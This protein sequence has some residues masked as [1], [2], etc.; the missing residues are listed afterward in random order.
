M[1]T[2]FDSFFES[3][4]GGHGET[5]HGARGGG[6][7]V[8]LFVCGRWND[9]GG[10]DKIFEFDIT[11]N[12][13]ATTYKV[14]RGANTV[15]VT[16]NAF[17]VVL[18]LDDMINALNADANFNDLDWDTDYVATV[19]GTKAADFDDSDFSTSVSGGTGTMTGFTVT[20]SFIAAFEVNQIHYWSNTD[21]DYKQINTTNPGLHRSTNLTQYPTCAAFINGELYAAGSIM[22]K[23]NAGINTGW[24]VAKY[25][26]AQGKFIPVFTDDT[27]KFTVIPEWQPMDGT[28]VFGVGSVNS[29]S[30]VAGQAWTFDGTSFTHIGTGGTPGPDREPNACGF[31]GDKFVIARAVANGF[32]DGVTAFRGLAYSSGGAWSNFGM[33]VTGVNYIR[34]YQDDLYITG[35]TINEAALGISQKIA[36]WDGVSA[37][38][39]VATTVFSGHVRAMAVYKSRL[40][41]AGNTTPFNRYAIYAYDKTDDAWEFIAEANSS[42]AVIQE[43]EVTPDGETLILGGSFTE[44]GGVDSHNLIAYDGSTFTGYQDDKPW[45]TEGSSS[46][47]IT[48]TQIL[49]GSI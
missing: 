19:T 17:G 49:F 2:D 16:G 40:Y 34:T 30:G 23:M 18:T 7:P 25:D 9:I 3:S 14:H 32:L 20:Q 35:L 11:S 39:D 28:K 13:T 45:H 8:N 10:Q 38:E 21:L 42:S 36:R 46:T 4:L 12:D 33:D 24:N 22:R 48:M 6:S 26:S 37:W 1:T 41:V 15:S 47:G 44:F 31:W 29:I 27:S 43:M 5:S